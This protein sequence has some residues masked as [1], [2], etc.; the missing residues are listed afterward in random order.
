[1]L[2]MSPQSAFASYTR[3]INTGALNVRDAAS[4]DSAVIGSIAYGTKVTCYGSSSGFTKIKY[5]GKYAYVGTSFLVS[6]NPNKNHSSSTTTPSKITDSTTTYKR[7]VMSNTLNIRSKASSS[8]AVIGVYKKGKKV[9]CYGANAGWTKVKYS[10]TYGYVAT[11]Y[12]SEDK[13]VETPSTSTSISSKTGQDVANYAKKFVGNPY[14]WGGESL[15]NGADCS[16][17]TKTVYKKFGYPLIHSASG[18]RSYGSAVGIDDRKP[19]DLICYQKNAQGNYHVAIY[20][21]N[22]QVVHAL[23][24]Q[25]GICISSWNFQ[26]VYSVRRLMK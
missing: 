7:Y 8:G 24:K 19:G 1:M 5:N 14:K 20:I 16:G 4:N 25:K 23:N 11:S 17:F 22:N 13:I 15:T 21:G 26:T 2:A 9:T 12:L 3:Y 18:Q 10:G 6:S